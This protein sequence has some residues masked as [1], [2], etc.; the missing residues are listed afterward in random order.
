MHILVGEAKILW[1]APAANPTIHFCGVGELRQLDA[2]RVDDVQ[3]GGV[4]VARAQLDEL[5]LEEADARLQTAQHRIVLDEARS[6]VH[7]AAEELL[8][9]IRARTS[10]KVMRGH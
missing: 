6:G 7:A 4:L 2:A 5:V 10:E 8:P 1:E 9:A 3:R